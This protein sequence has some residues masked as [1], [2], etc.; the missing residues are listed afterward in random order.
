M[1]DIPKEISETRTPEPKTGKVENV[2]SIQQGLED[3]DKLRAHEKHELSRDL[4]KFGNRPKPAF[5]KEDPLASEIQEQ[6]AQADDRADQHAGEAL[7]KMEARDPGWEKPNKTLER[8]DV[9][10]YRRMDALESFTE[11]PEAR[12]TQSYEDFNLRSD[13]RP[14][15]HVRYLSPD[16]YNS[17]EEAVE[18]LALPDY[19]PGTHET[20]MR[21]DPG[22]TVL[23][24]KV[25]PRFGHEG[26]GKQVFIANEKAVHRV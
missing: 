15:K 8:L 2:N 1:S 12:V 23:E 9:E 20:R 26:G 4:E 25:A 17:P 16:H 5:Y 11:P 14:P 3:L 21:V 7:K 18:K 24:G 19:N 10:P 13:G 22:T 6:K